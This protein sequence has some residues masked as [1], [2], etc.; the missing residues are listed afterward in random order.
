M[1]IRRTSQFKKDFKKLA[2]VPGLAEELAD[3]LRVLIAGAS[4]DARYQTHRLT[5]I[6]AEVWD[7]HVRPDTVVLYTLDAD[8]VTLLRIGSHS[9][10]FG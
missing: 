3:L 4:P 7:C 5:G 8:A 1:N 6:K 9:N 2:R 10:L